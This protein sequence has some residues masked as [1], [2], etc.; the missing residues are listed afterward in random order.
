M[1]EICLKITK[2][3]L[4][5]CHWH[6]SG[7]FIVNFEQISYRRWWL[8]PDVFIVNFG[9]TSQLFYCYVLFDDFEHWFDLWVLQLYSFL[10]LSF[11]IFL[12]LTSSFAF[13]S[14]LWITWNRFTI[15][16]S[17]QNY[18]T[19]IGVI[20]V[21]T[22]RKIFFTKDFFNKCD[23]IRKKLRIWSNF[24]KKSLMKNFFSCTAKFVSWFVHLSLDTFVF[25]IMAN[26]LI[27][28][29]FS[30]LFFVIADAAV[31]SFIFLL[32]LNFF[33][34]SFKVTKVILL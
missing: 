22:A 6:H 4:E 31:L 9:H 1:C 10:F 23:Q 5:R 12:R 32:F 15:L 8:R 28:F 30:K 34:T 26:L 13:L 11:F 18:L 27:S 14:K 29:L 7:V 2:T 16:C 17:Y 33:F 21:N 25:Y 20:F 24:M 3:I 19:L